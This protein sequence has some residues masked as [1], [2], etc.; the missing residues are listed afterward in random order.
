MTVISSNRNL[1]G[2]HTSSYVGPVT[3]YVSRFDLCQRNKGIQRQ[4]W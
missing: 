3:D 2:W 4:S 1:I